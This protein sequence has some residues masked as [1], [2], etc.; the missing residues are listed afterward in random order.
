MKSCFADNSHWPFPLAPLPYAYN[1]LEPSIDRRTLHFH[2]DKHL[3]T[4]LDNL[5]KALE[6]YPQYHDWSLTRLLLETHQLP[7][8]IITPVR[9]NAGGVYNHQLYFS[10]M[11][12][13]DSQP[14]PDI[15]AAMARDFGTYYN[16]KRQMKQTAMEVFGSGWAWLV[17][18]QGG[19]LKILPTANQD[20]PLPAFPLLVV[21]VWEHAYYLQYQNR[22]EEYLECWFK[23][24]NW[25]LVC[26]RYLRGLD[27]APATGS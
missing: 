7:E 13:G 12:C 10:A 6:P 27:C 18:D 17:L 15:L 19:K 21:D 8:D 24:I 23:L 14:C 3:K 16:W 26:R 11:T 4:Y 1:A 25:Q 9:R 2:H 20:T 22:R 5:N